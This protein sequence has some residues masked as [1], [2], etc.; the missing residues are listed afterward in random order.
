[1]S[2]NS[3][4]AS[5]LYSTQ[6]TSVSDIAGSPWAHIVYNELEHEANSELTWSTAVSSSFSTTPSAMRLCTSLMHS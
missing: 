4:L 5:Q 6:K 1:M 2:V 3:T